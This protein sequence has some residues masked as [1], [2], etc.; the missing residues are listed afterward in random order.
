MRNLLLLLLAFLM[1]NTAGNAQKKQ[2][3]EKPINILV[4]SKTA[5]FRHASISSGLKMLS[6]HSRGQNWVITA[7]EDAT[8]FTDDF[9][10]RFDVAVFL[11]PTGDAIDV[12]VKKLSRNL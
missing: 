6:D 5:G 8:L 12:K 2:E 1:I 7:T 3:F 4:F 10:A 11:N 9:L